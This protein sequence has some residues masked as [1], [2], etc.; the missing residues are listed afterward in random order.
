MSGSGR[1]FLL[2]VVP[3]R[4]KLSLFARHYRARR[5]KWLHL[6]ENAPLRYAPAVSMC[7]LLPGD[8]IS[9][10]IALTGLYELEA[11]RRTQEL[12]ARG[13]LMVD[14]GANLGYFSLLWAAARPDNRVMAFEA[15]PRNVPLL[16][17]NVERNGFG[18]RVEIAAVAVGKAPGK[19]GFS[20]G[21]QEQTGWGGVTMDPSDTNVTVDVVRLDD[22]V[23]SLPEIAL[24]KIDIEG[25]DTWALLGCERLLR[26]RRVKEIWFEANKPRMRSLGIEPDAA[27]EFLSSVNY[28]TRPIT[29]LTGD[30]V[31]WRSVPAAP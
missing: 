3:D 12:A 9:D 13:G 2:R 24:L 23:N 1:P 7:G 21:P 14:V 27:I 18:S 15:S 4:L 16:R 31:E 30:Q 17:R 8:V 6:Y 28:V 26:A 5:R 20:L 29:P 22:I 25:A 11:T 10:S 19:L